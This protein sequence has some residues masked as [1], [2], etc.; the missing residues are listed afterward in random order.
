MKNIVFIICIILFII[1][2]SS[3]N[4]LRKKAF[5]HALVGQNETVVCSRLGPPKKTIHLSEGEKILLFEFYSKG[6][7]TTPYKSKV[8]YSHNKD[9]MGNR[10][11]FALNLGENTVTNDPKYTI[12]Q[13]EVSTVKVYFNKRGISYRFEQ[14]LT[15]KQVDHFYETFKEYIPK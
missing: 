4:K 7:F 13:T 3:T 11:G 9:V 8:T 14:S 6:M 2:C 12:H 15:P 5:H 1:S 10:E